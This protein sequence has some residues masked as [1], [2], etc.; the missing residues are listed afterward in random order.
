MVEDVKAIQSMIVLYFMKSFDI[1]SIKI[2]T[3]LLD[4]PEKTY[5][6]CAISL[7]EGLKTV[8]KTQHEVHQLRAH[9]SR[10]KDDL[11]SNHQRLR[12]NNVEIKGVPLKDK[13]NLF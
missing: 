4:N 6:R 12:L 10:L 7:D 9:I 2:L 11:N 8:E 5:V 3:Y 1:Y 13:E